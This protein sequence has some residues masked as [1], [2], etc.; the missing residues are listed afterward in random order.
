VAPSTKDKIGM[1]EANG[2]GWSDCCID[3]WCGYGLSAFPK[4]NVLQA[5]TP[6]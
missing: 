6:V 1:P 3:R 2:T 4:V 5:W